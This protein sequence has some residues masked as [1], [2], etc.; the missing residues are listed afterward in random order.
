MFR[1][2][3]LWKTFA[4][5]GEGLLRISHYL[6]HRIQPRAGD[7]RHEE[8]V[9]NLEERERAKKPEKNQTRQGKRANK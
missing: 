3:D 5:Q 6:A 4:E 7:G 2:T 1:G 8:H 9:D